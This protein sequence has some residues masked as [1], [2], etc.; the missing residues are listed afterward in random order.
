M[1]KLADFS[2]AVDADLREFLVRSYPAYLHSTAST[3][4]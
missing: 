2:S 1:L 3:D 4:S